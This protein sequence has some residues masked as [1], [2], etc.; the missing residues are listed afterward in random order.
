MTHI[1]RDCYSICRKQEKKDLPYCT[2][3][4]NDREKKKHMT[5]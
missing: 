2:I 1:T 5:Q 3:Y 4:E